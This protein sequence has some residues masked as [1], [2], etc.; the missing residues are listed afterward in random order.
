MYRIL[1]FNRCVWCSD[2]Q[3]HE[4]PLMAMEGAGDNVACSGYFG[5]IGM[6]SLVGP[7]AILGW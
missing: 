3:S 5:F 6:A 1:S 4:N 7:D 2:V